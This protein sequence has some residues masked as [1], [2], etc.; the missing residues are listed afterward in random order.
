MRMRLWTLGLVMTALAAGCG[1]SSDAPTAR[2]TVLQHSEDGEATSRFEGEGDFASGEVAYTL[3]VGGEPAI[4]RQEIGTKTFMQDAGEDIYYESDETPEAL[5]SRAVRNG[6]VS[7]TNAV[8]HLRSIAEEVE[9][10]GEEEVRGTD[11]IHYRGL[12]H[13]AEMG[14]PPEYDRFP[15]EVWIDDAGRTRR[16]SY[17]P[18]GSESTV[19]WEFYDFG[20]SVKDLVPPPPEKVRG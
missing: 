14:A 10:V 9:E 6:L 16:Y 5:A 12:V 15:I 18:L 17:H 4:E 19:V 7:S 11:T 2:F 20:I 1:G 8:E 13:L 3:M